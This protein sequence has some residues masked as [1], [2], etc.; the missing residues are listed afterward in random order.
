M[1]KNQHYIDALEE[2]SP[3]SLGMSVNLVT[4]K[5]MKNGSLK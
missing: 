3:N 1:K 5:I 4:K 2:V